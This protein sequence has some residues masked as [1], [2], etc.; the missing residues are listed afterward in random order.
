[1]PRTGNSFWN[2]TTTTLPLLQFIIDTL[3]LFTIIS[4]KMPG[5]LLRI[6]SVELSQEIITPYFMSIHNW[7]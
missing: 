7:F 5:N 6:T 2:G 1:M 4:F 3:S